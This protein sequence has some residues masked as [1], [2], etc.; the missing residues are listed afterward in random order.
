MFIRKNRTP[1]RSKATALV[2]VACVAVP[3]T[4]VG[5]A[6]A[7]P[8]DPIG[9][10]SQYLPPNPVDDFYAAPEDLGKPGDLLKHRPERLV[11]DGSPFALGQRSTILYTSTT[12]FGQPVA[13]SGTII[14]PHAAWQGPGPRPTIVFAPGTRGQGDVCAPS[15]SQ[16]FIGAI[17]ASTGSVNVNYE[18][19][20]QLEALQRGVRV[21][22]TDYIGLGTAG[23]HSY[24]NH[25]EE[26][27][28][29]LDAARASL[30]FA[31]LPADSPIGF[32]G[33]SQGGGAAA[34]AAEQASSYAPEL[35]V[36]GTYAGAPPAD[37]LAVM[38]A[39]DR[40]SI[41][42]VLGMALNGYM[43]RF[44]ELRE[45]IYPQ[46]NERG[47]A[48]L[49]G[50]A[51]ACIPDAAV[52]WGFWDSRQLTNSG[53]PLFELVRENPR[54]YEII[55]AQ[56]LGA[57][58]P[59]APIMIHNAR[60]DDIV[61]HHQAVQLAR[62]Y[63]A[64]GATVYFTSNEVPTVVERTGLNHIEAFFTGHLPSMDFLLARFH[65]QPAPH[66]GF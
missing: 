20:A 46:L 52:K 6:H 3:L 36:K 7:V 56:K 59:N 22:V 17:Q 33:Y 24:V 66:G 21:V 58:A 2:A 40:S 1:R 47:R 38:D 16:D 31:G 50:A 60:N 35:N 37:L 13:V 45:V 43:E 9:L 34:A 51:E 10:S 4:G 54:A 65:D 57:A 39:V 49:A 25:I 44:P 27:H 23:L 63:A 26:G 30:K 29:V 32:Y 42:G 41:A 62:D 5:A 11:A 12:M 55:A 61:P 18:A 14:E 28:A 19:P 53:K 48:F 8:V 64:K 15:R